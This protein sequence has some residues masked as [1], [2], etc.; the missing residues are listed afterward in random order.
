MLGGSSV[1]EGKKRSRQVSDRGCHL[2][3]PLRPSGPHGRWAGGGGTAGHP[4]TTTTNPRRPSPPASTARARRVAWWSS[5]PAARCPEAVSWANEGA[6]GNPALGLHRKGVQIFLPEIR[7][8]QPVLASGLQQSHHGVDEDTSASEDAWQLFQEQ[9]R[10][11]P[12][13]S[14]T[15]E[16]LQAVVRVRS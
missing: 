5:D 4:A 12:A 2:T 16:V 15:S 10:E 13:R 9:T 3:P 11:T 7:P 1:L 14:V 6:R 8:Y